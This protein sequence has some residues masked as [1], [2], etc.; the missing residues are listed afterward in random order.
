MIQSLGRT[1]SSIT[2]IRFNLVLS[3]TPTDYS[4]HFGKR[5]NCRA[6]RAL[7][8]AANLIPA[9]RIDRCYCP[10][11]VPGVLPNRFVEGAPVSSPHRLWSAARDSVLGA[12]KEGCNGALPPFRNIG[13]RSRMTE[14]NCNPISHLHEM[15]SKTTDLQIEI[16]C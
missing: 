1:A 9:S 6:V 16:H 13:H 2:S 4:S 11:D 8:F 12:N 3:I 14:E 7:D 5:P 10:L 15:H